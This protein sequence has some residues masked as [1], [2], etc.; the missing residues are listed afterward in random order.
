MAYSTVMRN[1]PTKQPGFFESSARLN[2]AISA[3]RETA[4]LKCGRKSK[5]FKQ[6][7]A[8]VDSRETT[9]KKESKMAKMKQ[10]VWSV[11]FSS[12]QKLMVP[13]L[14]AC[15][16]PVG[17]NA[18]DCRESGKILFN[19]SFYCEKHYNEGR[20]FELTQLVCNVPIVRPELEWKKAERIETENI[21]ESL[22]PDE[23]GSVDGKDWI[24][25]LNETEKGEI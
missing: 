22:S 5:L 15:S 6:I 13:S 24:Q 2:S 7:T 18:Q 9:I 12:Q 16:V 25:E 14:E 3:D 20:E 17:M 11:H 23:G 1:S 21:L 19:N 4:T 8:G 10:H